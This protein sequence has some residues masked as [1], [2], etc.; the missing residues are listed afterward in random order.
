MRVRVAARSRCAAASLFRAICTPV[1]TR[2]AF[3]GPESGQ[4]RAVHTRAGE[5]AIQRVRGRRREG[6]DRRGGLHAFVRGR[7]DRDGRR[8]PPYPC[9][10]PAVQGDGEDQ[11][12]GVDEGLGELAVR[13]PTRR[14]A[15]TA[16]EH[17]SELAHFPSLVSR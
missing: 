17:C 14:V 9:V 4:T 13:V 16:N 11:P 8:A 3:A 10:A 5:G 12:R 15:F 2:R 7:G 6:C 1:L